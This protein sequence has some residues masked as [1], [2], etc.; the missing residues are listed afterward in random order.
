M[1]ILRSYVLREF[2]KPFGGAL[3]VFTFVLVSGNLIRLIELI[4]TKGISI[5]DVGKLF[6][7]QIPSLLSY[8]FPMA[9]LA[10]MLITL[11]RLSAD[12][13]ITAMK[14]SG[15]NIFR[16]EIP[17]IFIGLIFS[18]FA[19]V[20]N[21]EVIPY[22]RFA[23]RKIIKQVGIKNPAAY[24]E[25]GTFI[26]DFKDTIVF[27]YGIQKDILSNIRIYEFKE[28]S[29]TRTIIAKH[30]KFI[31]SPEKGMLK[32][33]LYNGT[34][35]EPSPN[36][37][38]S[39]YKLNFKTYSIT[40]N[41]PERKEEVLEKKPKEMNIAEL[42][43]ERNNIR[44]KNIDAS[45]L[46]TEIQKKISAS[47]ACLAFIL[48]AFPMGIISRRG[49]KPIAFILSLFVIV[50][51]YSLSAAGEALALQNIIKPAWSMWAA[52]VLIGFAGII[53]SLRVYKR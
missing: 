16:L 30:G 46:D 40:L 36:S 42:L 7:L 20:L 50:V 10:A 17:F 23:S 3:L 18:L 32:L 29:P 24:L 48:I 43:I 37:Q 2:A 51:Y 9:I 44:G 39:F 41:A 5:I 22:T 26:R 21:N 38:E 4:I 15:L 52:D 1:K 47:F 28:N 27:V 13:E 35:D 53:L 25:P 14:A 34:S 31:S 12:L 6:L 45:P 49:N 8:I 19:V 33:I 11:G